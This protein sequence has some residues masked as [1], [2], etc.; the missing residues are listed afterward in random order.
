M[1]LGGMIR[2]RRAGQQER[3]SACQ[4]GASRVSEATFIPSARVR[5]C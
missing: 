1:G 5:A 2:K 4:K 3:L